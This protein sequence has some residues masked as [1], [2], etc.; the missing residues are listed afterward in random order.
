VE[1]Q[2]AGVVLDIRETID[3]E[4]ENLGSVLHTQP[5]AGAQILVHPYV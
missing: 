2:L 3:V 5:V 4:L 1:L